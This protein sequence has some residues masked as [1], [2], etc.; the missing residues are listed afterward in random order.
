MDEEKQGRM[1]TTAGEDGQSAGETESSDT[2]SERH[3]G[4]VSAS[5][6]FELLGHEI[7]MGIVEELADC[8]R[9]NWFWLG[10]RFAEL[11]KAVGVRDAGKFSYHLDQLQP[12]FVVKDG[13]EY[14]LTYAGMRVAGA[15]TAGTYT[16]SEAGRE[17]ELD[18]NCLCG[19]SLVA[20]YDYEYC[21]IYCPTHGDL[22]GTTL[23]PGAAA[24]R[25][26]QSLVRIVARESRRAVEKAKH[27][28]CPHCWGSMAA[29]IPA[30]DVMPDP[31]TGRRLDDWEDAF[32]TRF[33]ADGT[34]LAADD[35]SAAG[36]PD[37]DPAVLMAQFDCKRCGMTIWW[38]AMLCVLDHPA[39]VSFC[40]DHGIDVRETPL[41]S[42]P[43]MW[44]GA[45]SVESVDPLRIAV[46][47]EL[48]DERLT[49]R[50]DDTATVVDHERRP[51]SEQ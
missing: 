48:D 30:P 29:A 38:P 46:D 26:L 37:A 25:T 6:A 40:Y 51:R 20:R 28:V 49:V 33:N 19:E 43:F 24:D 45:I 11:R 14:K 15:I 32:R 42:L 16:E 35:S 12:Q 44:F 8:R 47:A 31:E 41:P 22:G 23:P 34:D 10:M 13:E 7:R 17:T 18:A 4:S 21:R 1:E 50:L 9:D 3:A 2:A 39:V 36:V 27:G 5:E